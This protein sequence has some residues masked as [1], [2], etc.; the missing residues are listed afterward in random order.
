MSQ[1]VAGEIVLEK[2]IETLMV[3]CHRACR[4]RPRPLILP[5]GGHSRSRRKRGAVAMAS[6]SIFSNARGARNPV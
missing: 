4:G 1:A 2:L 5:H 6:G 3:Y